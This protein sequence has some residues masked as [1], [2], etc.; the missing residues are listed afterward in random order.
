ML[1]YSIMCPSPP[2]MGAVVVVDPFS[3]GANLAATAVKWGYRVI[4]VVSDML[5]PIAKMMAQDAGAERM[6]LVQH[7]SR[8]GTES[9]QEAALNATLKAIEQQEGFETKAPVLAII[10]GAETG[11]ELSE[12][13]ATRYGTRCNQ[14]IQLKNRRNKFR[15][16]ERL[17]ETGVRAVTQRLCRSAAE[18]EHFFVKVLGGMGITS[19]VVK[20][21]ESAGSDSIFLCSSPEE[22][23]EAF[24]KIHGQFNGL[25]QIN[26]GALCQEFLEGSEFVVDGVSRDGVYKVTAIWEYD[27]RHANGSDFV[28]FGMRLRSAMGDREQALVKYAEEVIKALHLM[29]GPS[30]ME[31]IMTPHAGPCL[32][33][34]GGR[35]HGGQGSWLPVTEECVGYSQ[36]EATLNCYLRPDRFDALPSVPNLLLK[37]GAE[38]FLVSSQ[39]GV[40]TSSPGVDVIRRLA[41]FRRLELFAQVGYELRPTVDCFT[42]PG[43]V[44]LV[45]ESPGMLEADY[46][47]VRSLES[48]GGMFNLR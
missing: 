13:L 6:L 3:T 11:V 2:I 19:C 38:V 8:P 1:D 32:V 14:E 20:P 29:Q 23:R 10:P 45:H 9:S 27:K 22:V 33:E 46:E 5:S 25:G 21:N 36:V 16:Q 40:V 31:I 17:R 7:D 48:S 26:D 28:Y 44:Q 39:S 42:R 24:E 34:V 43:S 35:C 18:I 47:A 15:M 4:L 30:H 41:S 37:Q 12:L